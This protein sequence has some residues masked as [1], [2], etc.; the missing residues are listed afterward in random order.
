MDIKVGDIVI[1]YE[2]GQTARKQGQVIAINGD[3]ATVFCDKESRSYFVKVNRL[4][5]V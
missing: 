2:T 4:K 1:W 5:K 3:T